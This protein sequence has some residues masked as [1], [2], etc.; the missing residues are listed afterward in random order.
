MKHTECVNNL[1]GEV[2]ALKEEVNE[3][4]HARNE[5][6]KEF[7]EKLA[8]K[9][10]EWMKKEEGHKDDLKLLEELIEKELEKKVAWD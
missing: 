7:K 9:K 4:E 10:E 2:V 8:T 3:R 6:E 5:I 1:R